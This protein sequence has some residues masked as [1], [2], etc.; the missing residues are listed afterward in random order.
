[1]SYIGR[2]VKRIEDFPLLSGRAKFVGDLGFSDQLHMRV[3]RSPIA[4]GRLLDID[5]SDARSL[6]GV[7]SVW[8]RDD[9]KDLPPID[10]R[11]VR[12]EE[13]TAYRQYVLAK[14]YVR[15]VGEPAAVVFAEDSYV[16]EDA[17]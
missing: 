3:V 8:T 7:I 2:S 13:L 15:Y 4:F 14:E 1:M 16:A 5:S 9:V 6:S 10:F 12:V 11:Q 17:A